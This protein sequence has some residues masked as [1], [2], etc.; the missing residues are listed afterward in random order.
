MNNTQLHIP[1]H[2]LPKNQQQVYLAISGGVD[3][4][5]LL[6]L[7]A[8]L[9]CPLHL[10]HVNYHLRAEASE[11]DEELIRQLADQYCVPLHVLD[12]QMKSH[13]E[14]NGGNLQNE[15]R[16]IRYD[17]FK[18]IVGDQDLLMTAHHFDDQM[19]TF[20]MHLSRKSGIAGMSCMPEKKDNH[21]RPLLNYR[22]TQLYT[23]AAENQLIFREDQSNSDNKYLRN[24]WRNVWIPKMEQSIPNLAEQI[25]LL[26]RIFQEER[27]QLENILL[28][29]IKKITKNKVWPFA[30]FD[31]IS[32][33]G[34]YLIGKSIGLRPSEV[35]RLPSLRFAEKSKFFPL[36]DGKT[37]IWNTGDAFVWKS[38]EV[39]ADYRIVITELSQMPNTF[40]KN[41]YYADAAKIK[42]KLAVRKWQIGDRI[43][44]IGMTG[45]QLI[46]DIIKDAKVPVYDKEN[47][48]VVV[49]EE[50][51]IWCVG[52]KVG[53]KAIADNT[54]Q[55]LLAITVDTEEIN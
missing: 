41:H 23:Y 18:K 27:A 37:N 6:D 38:R 8:Q 33:D 44:P 35:E 13:L 49:D 42:G 52:L 16:N 50:K 22:K 43:E 14:Q 20:F 17:Y 2:L 48:L 28:P 31:V 36:R 1:K 46:S 21:V 9:A 30:S 10:I 11:K 3:S 54:T 26:I 53:R 47:V 55:K 19:E 5:V 4:V 25:G 51:I 24:I 32:E 15:A 29:E 12:F 40:D 7:L 39:T 45:S 34:R